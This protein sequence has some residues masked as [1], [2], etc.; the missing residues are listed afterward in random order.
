MIL[1]VHEDKINIL[2]RHDPGTRSLAVGR[3]TGNEGFKS[4]DNLFESG[5]SRIKEQVQARLGQWKKNMKHF[6]RIKWKKHQLTPPIIPLLPNLF[7]CVCYSMSPRFKFSSDRAKDQFWV[8]WLKWAGRSMKENLMG[9]VG[10]L[11]DSCFFVGLI[12]HVSS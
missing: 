6:A 2:S 9:S 10:S 7:K 3:K 11:W 8:E 1:W 5:M 4:G 12:A